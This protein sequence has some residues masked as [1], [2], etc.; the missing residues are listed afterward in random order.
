MLTTIVLILIGFVI[1]AVGAELMVN[2]SSKLALHLGIKPLVVGLTIVAFGTSSPELAVSI[3]S[4]LSGLSAL[5]LGNVVGSNIA[6]IGLILGI[7][8]IIHPIQIEMELVRRQIPIVIGCSFLLG[9]LFLDG[10][11]GLIEGLGLVAGLI[12]FI[13]YSY[14]QGSQEQASDDPQL[15][16]IVAPKQRGRTFI[17]VLFILVGLG[18]LVYGSHLFVTNTV[19]LA[20][21]LGLSEAIIGLTL[22]AVGTS[23][24]ELA[25]SVSAAVRKQAD[26]A[27]GNVVG[28]N[29]FNILAVMGISSLFGTISGAQFS[30]VDFSVMMLFAL[31]LLPL[32]RTG[33][34]IR[35]LEGCL[36]LIAYGLYI[37]YLMIQAT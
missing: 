37:A 33:W 13:V 9:L 10:E 3:D 7:T 17:N 23:I 12:V 8:A 24:P 18:S 6:N 26:I 14:R 16:P 27:I 32:A 2:G 22:V 30:L 5:A 34:C 21:L 4:T 11:L 29:T 36:L 35:R 25:T 1:L 20:R 28:S 15:L 31:L 19:E